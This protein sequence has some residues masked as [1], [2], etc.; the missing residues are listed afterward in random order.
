MKSWDFTLPR[1]PSVNR[2]H[3][4]IRNH[5]TGKAAIARSDPYQSWRKMAWLELRLRG[6]IRVE[7]IEG[8]FAI[9]ISART[10]GDIDNLVKP[11]LDFLQWRGF[12]A[13]DN[14][15]RRVT[16]VWDDAMDEKVIRVQLEEL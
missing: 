4:I 1:P 16:I 3:R 14:N 13:D 7:A 10:R 6:L 9:L 12:I 2:T 8:E 11:T 15:A 5:K